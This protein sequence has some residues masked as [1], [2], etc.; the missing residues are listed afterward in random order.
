ME[1]LIG[2]GASPLFYQFWSISVQS[3]AHNVWRIVSSLFRPRRA[4][5]QFAC[6]ALLQ[7]FAPPLTPLERRARRFTASIPRDVASAAS[8]VS[9]LAARGTACTARPRVSTS[10]GA[11]LC[12]VFATFY[13]RSFMS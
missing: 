6:S 9:G 11:L 10:R 4:S 8:R 12:W 2:V 5:A 13:S 3:R 1:Q 7:P